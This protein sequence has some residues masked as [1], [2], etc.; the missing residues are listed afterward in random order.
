MIGLLD[1]H[2]VR[3]V[4]AGFLSALA[5]RHRVPGAQL[6][7][8]QDGDTVAVEVG[9][10]ESGTRRRVCRE[11][12]F[13]IGSITKSFTATLAMALV[14]D[15]DVDLDA[16]VGD[17]LPDLD[18]VGAWLTLRQ[19]LS[20]TGGLASGP[21]SD[22]ASAATARRYAIDHCTRRNLVLPPGTAFS[23]SNLGYVIAGWLIETVT[24][25]DWCEAVGSILLHPL[26][27]TPAFVGV[28]AGRSPRRPLATGHSVNAATG[29]ARPVRPVAAPAEAATGG[30]A[31]SATDLV[32][33]GRLH[34][35]AGV[36]GLLPKTHADR[37]RQPVP[38]AEPFGLAD[39]W[40]LGLAVFR[41]AGT[42]WVGHD[43]NVDGVSCYLRIDPAGGRVVAFTSN[44]NTGAGMWQDVLAELARAGITVGTTAAAAPPGPPV[45]PPPGCVGTYANGDAE[46][47][48]VNRGG[49]HYL[50]VDGEFGA[51]TFHEGLVFALRDPVRAARWWA[52]ASCATR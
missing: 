31:L 40:G 50:G 29:R 33:L 20:H 14:A 15:G 18:D 16:P 32:A 45:A 4:R 22:E 9:E 34:L 44:A 13:P 42:D 12:A 26:G 48:V 39:A 41:H 37:M 47:V 2:D 1:E 27:I 17:Y 52:A 10:L 24:G 19:L 30:L 49:R 21:E 8:H 11:S 38:A 28:P 35:G 23:Y 36:P 25:M 5:R 46:F 6:A 7:V 51:L 3:P 43:G